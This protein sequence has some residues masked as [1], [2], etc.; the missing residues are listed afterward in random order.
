M[1]LINRYRIRMALRLYEL[2]EWRVWRRMERLS[3]SFGTA[4]EG[5]L[6]EL[7]QRPFVILHFGDGPILIDG[8]EPIAEATRH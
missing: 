3:G 4:T 7:G 5:A 1:R 2:I 6:N 8:D